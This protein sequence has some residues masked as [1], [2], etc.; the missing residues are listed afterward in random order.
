MP[1]ATVVPIAPP[2]AAAMLAGLLVWSG[3]ALAQPVPTGETRL[4]AGG[5]PGALLSDLA[6]DPAGGYVVSWQVVAYGPGQENGVAVRRLAADGTPQ[7]I[8]PVATFPDG[9]SGSHLAVAVDPAG[10]MLGVWPQSGAFHH[11]LLAARLDQP[12]APRTVVVAAVVDVPPA[13]LAAAGPGR[14]LLASWADQYVSAAVHGR[15]L[16]AAG[17]PLGDVFEVG[18]T[19]A[20][21][22]P[23]V[24]GHASGHAAVAWA[25]WEN[26]T[27]VPRARLYTPDGLPVAGEMALPLPPGGM[28]GGDIAL[29]TSPDGYVAAYPRQ[30]LQNARVTDRA[31]DVV[32][33]SITGVAASAA[34][35]VA[36][37]ADFV[38]AVD[39][40]V[41]SNGVGLVVWI[42]RPLSGEGSLR[43]ALINA[44]GGT[45]SAALTLATGDAAALASAKVAAGGDGRFLVAWGGLARVEGRI[46][47]TCGNGVREVGEA[48]EDGNLRAGDC[49]SP[50]CTVEPVAGTCW[51]LASANVLRFSATLP[52]RSGPAACS[53]RCRSTGVTTL[54]LLDDGTYRWPQGVLPCTDGGQILLPDET[55]RWQQRGARVRLVPDATTAVRDAVRACTGAK[56]GPARTTLR[57]RGE[58]LLDGRLVS[59]V[60]RP[61]RP[62]VTVRSEGRLSGLVL[63]A[64]T[65]VPPA[66]GSR[67]DA[68]GDQVRLRCRL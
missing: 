30:R 39:V 23:A 12:A 50:T 5:S 21:L 57:R 18:T 62:P 8:R 11:D 52:T 49:C 17:D 14:F 13:G 67:V 60:R 24:A 51:Q 4:L 2:L 65:A 44:Y 66:F 63:G 53:A 9:S 45:P 27:S 41:G 68:C 1:A 42:E 33:L 47:G 35:P 58:A 46:V 31:I 20:G 16:D 55:G 56:L 37:T 43:A 36:E 26:G 59:R 38:Y 19:T 3:A 40:A 22:R 48:C 61:G 28:L 7:P 25:A 15:W 34:I 64:G 32:P 29:A 10:A 54:I 6:A